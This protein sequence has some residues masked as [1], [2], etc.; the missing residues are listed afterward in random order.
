MSMFLDWLFMCA[1]VAI[2][3]IGVRIVARALAW[4]R[5]RRNRR[6]SNRCCDRRW[7]SAAPRRAD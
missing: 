4:G 5:K 7:K 3:I 6:G 1:G 2:G